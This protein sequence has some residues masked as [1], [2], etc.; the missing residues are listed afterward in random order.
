MES[1]KE[2]QDRDALAFANEKLSDHIIRVERVAVVDGKAYFRKIWDRESKE[3]M[4]MTSGIPSFIV[5]DGDRFR[6]SDEE[7][8]DRVIALS[9]K[10]QRKFY[11]LIF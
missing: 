7:E 3:S 10:P 6:L 2:Q 4:V 8:Y 1:K 5:L 11:D 9:R